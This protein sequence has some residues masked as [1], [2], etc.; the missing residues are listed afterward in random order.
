MTA[1]T[2]LGET[3][4]AVDPGAETT[5]EVLVR[6]QSPVVDQFTVDVVGDTREWT[7][8]DPPIVN[9]MPGTE[10]TLQVTFAPPRSAEVAA[11]GYPF[12][13]RVQSRE[14]PGDS[15]VVEGHVEVTPFTELD[16]E[17]LPT[18][19]RGS[20]RAKYQ[21]AVENRGNTTIRVEVEPFDPEDDRIR[22]RPDRTF[23][24]VPPARVALLGVLVR[25]YERFLRGDPQPHPFELKVLHESTD[26]TLLG[27][28]RVVKGLMT[29]ERM[30][31]KWVIP[32]LVLICALGIV[33]V[34]L[35]YAV[36]VPNVKNI[37]TS[38]VAGQVSQAGSAAAAA[39][40]AAS[41]AH[42]SQQSAQAQLS[43]AAS[44]SS[45]NTPKPLDFRVA[46]FAEPVT[47]GSY[48]PFTFTAPDGRAMDVSDAV[49]QNP[50][51]DKGFIR[52]SVGGQVLL[53][54]GLANFTDQNYTYS[55]GL[56]VPQGVPVVVSVNCVTPGPG[57]VRCTPSVS[58]SAQV[59]PQGRQ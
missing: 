2:L 34:A 41:D 20:R 48:Q 44:A 50:R 10:V 13:V 29:Q 54:A 59:L 36:L 42:G 11:G 45:A 1:F 17:L 7:T 52:L 33:L 9:L 30:L 3:S 5:C 15:A 18:K 35:W 16:A 51:G 43:A 26:G 8:A 28:P 32:A 40:A 12:G 23:F 56:H 4:F 37:A 39:G 38:E 24:S 14:Y 53:E 49:M 27:E 55:K 6:N 21:L 19:R 31:P 22:I 57:S 58:F 25:P 47:D 46:A